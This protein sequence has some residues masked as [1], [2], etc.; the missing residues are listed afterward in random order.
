M[1][2]LKKLKNILSKLVEDPFEGLN[3][4]DAILRL[5]IEYHFHEEIE[6]ILKRQY[7]IFSGHAGH[8]HD[9]YEAALHFRLLR[10]VGYHVSTGENIF[11]FLPKLRYA[12]NYHNMVIIT[13]PRI[14]WQIAFDSEC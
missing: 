12:C 8:D 6:T 9:L 14:G 3:M 1:Q 4:V 11:F 2:K 7:M 5:G 10:Q 13:S